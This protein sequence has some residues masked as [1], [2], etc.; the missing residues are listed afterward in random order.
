MLAAFG[1]RDVDAVLEKRIRRSR[2]GARPLEGARGH[3]GDAGFFVFNSNAW[4][5]SD[6]LEAPRLLAVAVL[7]LGGLGVWLIVAHGLWESPARSENATAAWLAS[8]LA[9]V[10]GAIG[11]GLE[12][13]DEV[14]ETVSRY[15]P[16]PKTEPSASLPEA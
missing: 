1:R 3:T 4:S 14:R 7:A 5:V 13:D 8:S 11:S 10:A 2:S 16:E 12:S 15:R 6:Q 9:T